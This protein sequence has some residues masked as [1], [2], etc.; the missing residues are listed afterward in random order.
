MT[1][2]EH[3]LYQKI[4]ELEHIISNLETDVQALLDKR[5]QDLVQ[6]SKTIDDQE[7][8][9]DSLTTLL[10]THYNDT[11]WFDQTVSI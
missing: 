6:A 7:R 9:I 4:Q 1:Y 11:S 10:I 2:Q 5:Y 8:K 3:L